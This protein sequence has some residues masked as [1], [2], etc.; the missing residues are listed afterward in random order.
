LW[1]QQGHDKTLAYEPWPVVNEEYLREDTFEYPVSF[2]GKLR[3]KIALPVNMDKEEI[4]RI[5]LADERAKKW[6]SSGNLS[7]IIV[8]PNRIVNI[9]IKN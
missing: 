4:A 7:N 5:V 3:F 8:V 9:V 2:N 6:L 1:Q